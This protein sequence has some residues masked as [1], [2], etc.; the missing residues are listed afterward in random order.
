MRNGAVYKLRLHNT[1]VK[2]KSAGFA[3]ALKPGC[4]L[5]SRGTGDNWHPRS[6][7][8]YSSCFLST[9]TKIQFP[10]TPRTLLR[11]DSG[12]ILGHWSVQSF[13]KYK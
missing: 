2:I 10:Q 7:L 6:G 1:V 8:G 4:G 13:T 3:G 12:G 11:V 5:L 9:Y